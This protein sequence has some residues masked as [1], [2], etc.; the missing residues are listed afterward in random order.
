MTWYVLSNWFLSK[1]P[2]Y[3]MVVHTW[4][5]YI[6]TLLL[7]IKLQCPGKGPQRNTSVGAVKGLCW[8]SDVYTRSQTPFTQYVYWYYKL[9]NE[10]ER[11]KMTKSNQ[12]WMEIK[13]QLYVS[14]SYRQHPPEYSQISGSKVTWKCKNSHGILYTKKQYGYQ[15]QWHWW[16]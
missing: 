13:T 14:W 10:Q 16:K 11:G 15:G 1:C 5:D 7:L 12:P 9:C 8:C 3:E 2:F 6:F 4:L